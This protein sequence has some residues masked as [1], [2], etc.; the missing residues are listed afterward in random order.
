MKK[1]YP[2]FADSSNYRGRTQNTS[3]LTG[4]KSADLRIE[5]LERDEYT[6]AYCEFQ[7]DEWQTINYV[8]GDST[9]NNKSNLITACPMCNLILNAPLGCQQEGIVELYQLSN[10]NQNRMVQIT[11]KMRSEGKGDNEIRRFLGLRIKVPFK[12]KKEYLKGLF[13]FV[14]AWKGSWGEVEEGLAFGYSR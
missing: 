4:K 5:V 11:R 3:R 6:C 10:F 2:T 9:N 7:A 14:T 1:L 13:A 8:D 12:M